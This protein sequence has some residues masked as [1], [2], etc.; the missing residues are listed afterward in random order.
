MQN[1]CGAILTCVVLGCSAAID[2]AQIPPVPD[3]LP[4]AQTSLGFNPKTRCPDLRIADEGTITV[5]VFWL[6]RSGIASQ[7][8]IKSSSGSNTLDSA[9]VAC[10]S[11]LRFSP[12]TTVGTG[13]PVDSWQRVAF[14]WADQGHTDQMRTPAAPV[15][16]APEGQSEANGQANTVTVHVCT[17]EMGKLKEAPAIVHSSGVSALDQAAV[18]I[19]ASGSAYYRP[20]TPSNG[21]SV[22]GC[23]Q[24]AI[25]FDSK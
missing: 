10:V 6:S 17:D 7:V 12:A 21:P 16:G 24:L 11:K 4:W 18:K 9:A 14:R 23:A 2:A 8:S 15:Q 1:C 5:V 13:D 22:S 19:A 3:H 25:K 20:G